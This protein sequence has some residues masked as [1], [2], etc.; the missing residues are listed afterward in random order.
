MSLKC[1]NPDAIRPLAGR[2]RSSAL[3]SSVDNKPSLV[4]KV[5]IR[6]RLISRTDGIW[7]STFLPLRLITSSKWPLTK[8]VRLPPPFST[9]R[10][11]FDQR[12]LRK[13]H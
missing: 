8:E 13:W 3:V 5:P 9:A 12:I 7:L 1:L 11:I 10:E 2:P 4:Y 6:S